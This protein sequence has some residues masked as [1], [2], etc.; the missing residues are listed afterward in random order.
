[1]EEYQKTAIDMNLQPYDDDEINEAI[2]L[3]EQLKCGETHYHWARKYTEFSML[4]KLREHVGLGKWS[5]NYKLASRNINADY[6]EMLS[7]FA[8]S[9]AKQDM[10]LVGSSNS[11]MVEPLT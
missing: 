2:R 4:E 5:H 10:L 6:S 1:M 7:L 9:E 8:M 11:G 3:K